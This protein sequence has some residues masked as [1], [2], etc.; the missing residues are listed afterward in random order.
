MQYT[1]HFQH[2]YE[3]TVRT[4]LAQSCPKRRASIVFHFIRIAE[5]FHQLRNFHSEFAIL[6][7]FCNVSV[8]RLKVTW[9]R[10]PKS[11][12]RT[13]STLCE[14]LSRQDNFKN[15]LEHMDPN[16]CPCIPYIG[17]FLKDIYSAHPPPI[18]RCFYVIYDK[19]GSE[20]YACPSNRQL[21]S[22]QDMAKHSTPVRA[23][24]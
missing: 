8:E 20:F 14:L 18:K 12:R 9:S 23:L 7:A 5:V 6:S 1:S 17:F 10:I 3:W 11:R 13:F 21:Q 22:S 16:L 15:L 2:L 4:V 24:P 19:K